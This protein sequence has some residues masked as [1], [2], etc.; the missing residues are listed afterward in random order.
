VHILYLV[1][2]R[3]RLLVLIEWAW[4]YLGYQRGTRLITG[5]TELPGWHAAQVQEVSAP[6]EQ[7]PAAD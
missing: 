3:N 1:G 2:F 5:P 4:A 6:A 7:R